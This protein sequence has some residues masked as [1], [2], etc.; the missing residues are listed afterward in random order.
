MAA[1]RLTAITQN[2]RG[3]PMTSTEHRRS[4]DHAI[5]HAA[6]ATNNMGSPALEHPAFERHYRIGELYGVVKIGP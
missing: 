1:D 2:D 4:S 5:A 6:T 3:N